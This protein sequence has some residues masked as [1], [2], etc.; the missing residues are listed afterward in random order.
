MNKLNTIK[1]LEI[2]LIFLVIYWFLYRFFHLNGDLIFTHSWGESQYAMWTKAY[3]EKGFFFGKLEVDKLYPFSDYLPISAIITAALVKL[4]ESDIVFT[5]RGISFIASI[6]SAYYFYKLSF[7]IFNERIKAAVALY[8]FTVIPLNMYFSRTFFNDPIHLFFIIILFYVY[9]QNSLKEKVSYYNLKIG[10]IFSLILISKPTSIFICFMPILYDFLARNNRQKLELGKIIPY[11]VPITI[12]A[13]YLFL[14]RFFQEGANYQESSKLI[15]VDVIKNFFYYFDKAHRQY[16]F[17][18]Q[19]YLYLFSVGFLLSIFTKKISK[20][21]AWMSIGFAIFYILFIRGSVIHQYYSLP[22][23]IPFSILSSFSIFYFADK[24]KNNRLLFTIA[25]IT[26][27]VLFHP[28]QKSITWAF[29]NEYSEEIVFI[30]DL[31]SREHGVRNVFISGHGHK[32][33]QYYLDIPS[34]L[35]HQ[36]FNFTGVED[37]KLFLDSNKIDI[38]IVTKKQTFDPEIFFKNS[39]FDLIYETKFKTREIYSVYSRIK[40]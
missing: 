13:G 32:P 36:N 10:I 27:L 16:G 7:I 20:H 40:N 21:F 25:I 15:N 26:P 2:T 12:V 3:L 30:K 18:F 31:V 23:I 39:N 14:Y 4:M 34:G 33:L 19:G 37:P 22:F 17:G 6:L 28:S 24:L 38:V 5:G 1:L 11:I 35:K 9:F 29:H 8:I